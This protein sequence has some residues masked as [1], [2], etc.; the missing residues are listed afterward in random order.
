MLTT[1]R[2]PASLIFAGDAGV[3]K[4]QFAI[5]LAK[6]VLCLQPVDMEACNACAACARIARFPAFPAPDDKHRDDYK[7]VFWSEHPDVG[8]LTPYKNTILVDAVRDLVDQSNFTPYEGKARFFL[9]DEADKLNSSNDSAANALLKTLEEPA[10]TTHLILLTSRPD[11]LLQTI[12]SRCQILR[13]AP[14]A[15]GEIEKYLSE[16]SAASKKISPNDVKLLAQIARGSLGRALSTNLDAYKQQRELMLGVLESIA[17]KPDRA[18]LL[19]IAE[20][21]NDAKIKDEYETLLEIL[22][23]L[24][25]DVWTLRLAAGDVVNADLQPK[26]I[27][28]AETVESRRAQSWLAEIENLRENLAVNV[29]R[30]I[31]TDSLFMKM[32]SA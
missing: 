6:A 32:A 2:V 11:F 30:K 31:A 5:E 19:K 15:A 24:I 22:Q 3:G 21:L 12:R 7:K 14:I 28:F 17:A 25:H 20:E 23:T 4:R 27:K 10:P 13:F 26:L 16:D 1:K 18:R 29:N 9:V 8:T